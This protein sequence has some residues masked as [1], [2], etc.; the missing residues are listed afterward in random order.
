MFKI[1]HEF[2]NFSLDGIA[3]SFYKVRSL[4]REGNIAQKITVKSLVERDQNRYPDLLL[5]INR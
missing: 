3:G 5:L 2:L 1:N 4:Y